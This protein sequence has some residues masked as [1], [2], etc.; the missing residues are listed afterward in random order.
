[1]RFFLIPIILILIQCQSQPYEFSESS[2]SEILKTLS[3]DEMRGRQ[4]FTEDIDKAAEFINEQF[5]EIDLDKLDSESDYLQNFEVLSIRAV[6]ADVE[7]EG[8]QVSAENYF[9]LG[10]TS[11]IEWAETNEIKTEHI[12]AGENFQQ[13]FNEIRSM[14]VEA[15]VFV[16]QS[17]ENTFRRYQPF[18][19]RASRTFP[20]DQSSNKIFA[21][22]SKSQQ[23]SFSAYVT[24]E[25]DFLELA[26]VVGK[27]EGNRKDEYVVF[28]AHYD[29][30]GI[31]QPNTA[32]AD[33][34]ANGANDNASGTTAVIELAKYFKSK[35]K[36]ERTLLFVAFTAE[37]SGGYGSQ[38]F[39]K[40][41]EPDQIMA[42]FN[43]E[44]I[45]K[46]A[47]EGPNTAWITGFEKS[48]FGELLQKSAEGTIYEF[49]PDPYPNQNLFYRSDNATLAR[50]GVPAHTISTTPIDVDPDY[51]QV[52]DEFETINVVHLTNTIR[53]ISQAAVG[54]VSGQ[55]TPT[56]VDASQLN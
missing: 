7:I 5:K 21:L 46:P 41:L 20:D 27:I 28:S 55:D 13:R 19:S 15:F 44:M 33:S 37:E 9:V 40:Q 50:L 47:V 39:S 38:Y 17:H 34:I 52:S 36:P 54:I 4:A 16:D 31:R 43:I 48:S 3:S 18:F 14:D 45:G 6:N 29:H 26:N 35:G 42:M 49:Y 24:K 23:S 56:R 10:D 8:V 2:S 51:H 30:I 25:Y 32:N 22:T 1:M 11:T 12:A 53:A